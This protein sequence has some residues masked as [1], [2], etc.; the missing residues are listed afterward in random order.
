MSWVPGGRAIPPGALHSLSPDA[1]AALSDNRQRSTSDCPGDWDCTIIATASDR[2]VGVTLGAE[3][4][5]AAL[6]TE[7]SRE[8]L[9]LQHARG[10]IVLC[11]AAAKVAAIDTVYSN[12]QD[13]EGLIAET[14]CMKQMGFSGK[15]VS[16]PRQIPSIHQ[17]FAPTPEEVERARRIVE[18]FQRAEAEGS[19]TVAVDGRMIDLPVVARARRTLA[20]ADAG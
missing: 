9:E 18:V 2:V 16:H 13:E 20:L 15:S 10:Q 7:R 4:L 8:G 14:R 11:A 5:A 6:G 1:G 3:D 17:L 19:G 12:V